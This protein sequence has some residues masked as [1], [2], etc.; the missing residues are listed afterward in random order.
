M[1]TIISQTLMSHEKIFKYAGFILL[2]IAL[3]SL[4]TG[5]AIGPSQG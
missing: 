3:L 1:K 2:G 5:C 4:M